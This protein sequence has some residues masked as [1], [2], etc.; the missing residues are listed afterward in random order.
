MAICVQTAVTSAATVWAAAVVA[1]KVTQPPFPSASWC[2]L[3]KTY[4]PASTAH[5]AVCTTEAIH[6]ALMV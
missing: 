1:G 5:C 4:M 3:T 6:A 2:V